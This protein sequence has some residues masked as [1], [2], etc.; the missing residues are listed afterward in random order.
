MFQDWVA[1]LPKCIY[2]LMRWPLDN[3]VLPVFWALADICADSGNY[4]HAPRSHPGVI[5]SVIHHHI[6]HR[7]LTCVE[8]SLQGRND[9]LWVSN[10]L[11][12]TANHFKHLVVSDV[13]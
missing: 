7:C 6:D 5:N 11:G 1:L 13:R 4:E 10:I 2:Y 8:G 3:K 12:V 9:I